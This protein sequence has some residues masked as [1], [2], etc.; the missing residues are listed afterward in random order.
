MSITC[1]GVRA[2]QFVH[3]HATCIQLEPHGGHFVSERV[4]VV[5]VMFIC[6]VHFSS[7][8]GH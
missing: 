3:K 2:Y 7:T 1:F 8:T 5:L 6:I 4:Y